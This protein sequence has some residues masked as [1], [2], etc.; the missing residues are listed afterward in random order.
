MSEEFIKT[1]TVDTRGTVIIGLA[2]SLDDEWLASWSSEPK[3]EIR[4]AKT[5]DCIYS[6]AVE[7]RLPLGQEI[8]FSFSS[9]SQRILIGSEQPAIRDIVGCTW[10]NYPEIHPERLLTSAFS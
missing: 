4:N 7:Q 9:D 1:Q 6:I 10:T 8:R 5:G 3:V 2:F